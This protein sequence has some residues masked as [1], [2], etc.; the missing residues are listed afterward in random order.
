MTGES[1]VKLSLQKDLCGHPSLRDQKYYSHAINVS[2]DELGLQNDLRRHRLTGS[3]KTVRDGANETPCIAYIHNIAVH[4][5]CRAPLTE[6]GICLRRF[7][8]FTETPRETRPCLTSAFESRRNFHRNSPPPT[9]R[10]PWSKMNNLGRY[11]TYHASRNVRA[12]GI[13]CLS[14]FS[15]HLEL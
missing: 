5:A 15:H 4:L 7:T 3:Q 13:D 2:F 10:T 1:I 8:G 6:E 14:I 11:R 12:G 9:V